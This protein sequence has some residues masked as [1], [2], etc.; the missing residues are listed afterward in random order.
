MMI[1]ATILFAIQA[2]KQHVPIHVYCYEGC[3]EEKVKLFTFNGLSPSRLCYI[4]C[5]FE[6]ILEVFIVINMAT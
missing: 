4:L 6:D 3:N 5:Y 1:L 2:N